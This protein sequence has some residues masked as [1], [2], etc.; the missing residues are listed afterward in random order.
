MNSGSRS[1]TDKEIETMLTQLNNPRDYLLVYLGSKVGLRISELL[2][3]KTEALR[4]HTDALKSVL[5]I[6]KANVKGKGRARHIPLSKGILERLGTY[7]ATCPTHVYLFQSKKTKRGNKPR[8][9]SRHQAHRIISNVAD[10]AGLRG[11]VSSHSL[12]KGYARKLYE[13]SGKDLHKVQIALGH[14]SMNSTVYYLG[15]KEEE[16]NNL[17]LECQA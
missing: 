8:P 12:R 10:K 16:V 6:S 11:K 9:I 1:L 5:S 4:D 3:I 2:S 13:K 17:I 15:T 7:L 14:A